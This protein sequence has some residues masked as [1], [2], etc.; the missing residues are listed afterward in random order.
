MALLLVKGLGEGVIRCMVEVGR[1]I[2][3]VLQ[4]RMGLI[5]GLP[6]THHTIL[7]GRTA[8]F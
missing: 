5:Y 1:C 3:Y 7:I 4:R 2:R 8:H 6:H